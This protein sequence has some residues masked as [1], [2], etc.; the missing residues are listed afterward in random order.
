T[1]AGFGDAPIASH[2]RPLARHEA[3]RRPGRAL[4]NLRSWSQAYAAVTKPGGF[5]SVQARTRQHGSW[6]M[7]PIDEPASFEPKASAAEGGKP[8]TTTE[9]PSAADLVAFTVDAASGAIVKIERV[10]AAGAH[11]ELSDTDRASL[12]KNNAKS[13]LERLV[14]QAFEAGIACVLGA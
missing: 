8:K 14:E 4:G 7:P 12:A 5:R 3:R 9:Q 13:T 6:E 1:C 11:H 10:D 2:R